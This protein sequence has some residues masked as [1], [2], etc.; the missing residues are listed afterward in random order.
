VDNAATLFIVAGY[1]TSGKTTLLRKAVKARIA[2]FGEAY[3]DILPRPRPSARR[4]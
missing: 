3:S 4:R 1:P 2:L